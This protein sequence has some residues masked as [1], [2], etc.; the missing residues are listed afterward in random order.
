MQRLRTNDRTPLG[1]VGRLPNP[2]SAEWPQVVAVEEEEEAAA[3][4]EMLKVEYSTE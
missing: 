1:R 4:Q 3:V 2:G